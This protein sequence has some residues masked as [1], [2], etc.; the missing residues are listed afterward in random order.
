MKDESGKWVVERI[1]DVGVARKKCDE[2]LEWM[3]ELGFDD[4]EIYQ[5]V[6]VWLEPIGPRDD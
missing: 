2:F 3:R 5:L 1:G 6:L 4:P